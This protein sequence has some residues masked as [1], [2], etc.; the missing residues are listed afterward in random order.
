MSLLNGSTGTQTYISKKFYTILWSILDSGESAYNVAL[1]VIILFTFPRVLFFFYFTAFFIAYRISYKILRKT[2][3]YVRAYN[4]MYSVQLLSFVEEVSGRRLCW[5]N[6]NEYIIGSIKGT[7]LHKQ[8]IENQQISIR[9]N[10][11]KDVIKIK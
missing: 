11:L 4:V 6:R 8:Q 7:R 9:K 3:A 5:N 10:E 2:R 1:H